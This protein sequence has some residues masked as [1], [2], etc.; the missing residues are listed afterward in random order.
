MWGKPGPLY[1]TEP[2]EPHP[3]DSDP[4]LADRLPPLCYLESWMRIHLIIL[5]MADTMPLM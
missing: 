1:A 3:A 2:I 4:V 5:N